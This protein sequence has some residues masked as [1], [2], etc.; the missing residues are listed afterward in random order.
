MFAPHEDWSRAGMEPRLDDLLNDPIVRLVMRR[1]KVSPGDLLKVVARARGT[2]AG[3]RDRPRRRCA[4]A[5][6]SD[7]VRAPIDSL[8]CARERRSRRLAS[9][10]RMSLQYQRFGADC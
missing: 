2:L 9:G 3:P 1:D 6:A 4:H 7:L 10:H 8:R 5:P